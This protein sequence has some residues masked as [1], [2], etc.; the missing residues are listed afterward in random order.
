MTLVDSSVWIG[1]FHKPDTRVIDLLES[2]QILCHSAVLGE[3][4]AGTLKNR[5]RVLSDLKMIPLVS[6]IPNEEIM[7]FIEMRKL[8]GR[9]LG[10]ID[11]QLLASCVASGQALLTDDRRLKR[12]YDQL[13]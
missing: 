8:H 12:A 6:E 13:K 11:I 5:V 10:W 9:G 1:H 3:L 4:A 2:G 7:E